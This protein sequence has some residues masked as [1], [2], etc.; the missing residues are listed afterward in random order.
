MAIE[1][2][3]A[4]SGLSVWFSNDI[5]ETWDRP[6]SESGL[7]LEAR[8]WALSSH[9]DAPEH[10][11]AGTD[12]GI[13]RWDKETQQWSHLSSPMDSLSIWSLAQ[14]PHDPRLILAGTQPAALYLS[15]NSGES[16]EKLSA[17]LPNSCQF[18][19]TPR[20]THV[21]FD[22]VEHDRLW[23]G[24]EIGGVWTS[25]NNG[26]SWEARND[27]LISEDIH[28]LSISN[29][30]TQ[31]MFATTNKGLHVSDDAGTHW[32]FQRLD[33][34]WQYCRVIASRPDRKVL[35]LS[36]G[37]GPPGSNGRLLKSF[38]GGET[39]CD[40]HLPGT[41]NST[42]WCLAMHESDPL[43][44]FAATN[45]GQVFRSADGGETWTKLDREFGEIRAITWR[46]TN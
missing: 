13:Y 35:F 15:K 10:L 9:P 42:V 28:G 37:N 17:P 32:N 34:P 19:G 14:A 40:A 46:P 24:V 30:G 8:V 26:Q 43:L 27:G 31:K 20:V 3:V 38:D 22:P 1:L 41:L 12:S 16:W 2:S 45:L 25:D 23:A 44:V 6:Y 11:Y 7:Y 21:S 5:G 39:W 4:T 18:V 36:N 29:N 33:S